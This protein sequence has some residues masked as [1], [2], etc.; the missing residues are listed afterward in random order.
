MR[1]SVGVQGGQDVNL[2][3]SFGKATISTSYGIDVGAIY[4]PASWLRFGVVA[5]DL[6]QPEFDA[7]GGGRIN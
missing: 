6:N 1:S 4:R 3:K 5:K 2:S 7:P